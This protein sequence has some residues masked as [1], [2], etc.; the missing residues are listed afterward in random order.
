MKERC[1]I[2]RE[3]VGREVTDHLIDLCKSEL[4]GKGPPF[5]PMGEQGVPICLYT[6]TW[7][8]VMFE[9]YHQIH[10][11]VILIERKLSLVHEEDC[12]IHI[13]DFN[14]IFVDHHD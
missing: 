5:A 2:S 3:K 13:S 10:L 12:D 7:G 14:H 11:Q 9:V 4:L 1:L 6:Y 8:P